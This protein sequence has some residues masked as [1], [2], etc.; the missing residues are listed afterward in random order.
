MSIIA[1]IQ[2][3]WCSQGIWLTAISFVQCNFQTFVQ[4]NL[5]SFVQVDFQDFVQ[6]KI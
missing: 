6:K 4:G 1:V 5:Q 3:T 2:M